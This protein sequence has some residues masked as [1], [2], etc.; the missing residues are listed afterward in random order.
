MSTVRPFYAE[1]VATEVILRHSMEIAGA[2]LNLCSH[3][4]AVLDLE[5]FIFLFET[6][7]SLQYLLHATLFTIK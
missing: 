6:L 5:I 7:F 3:R 4:F 2:N 1:N